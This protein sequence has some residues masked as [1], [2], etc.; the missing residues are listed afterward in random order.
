MTSSP[1][2]PE[3][4]AILRLELEHRSLHLVGFV[5]ADIR[6]IAHH[7][8]EIVDPAHRFQHIALQKFHPAI[9]LQP[10][11][12]GAGNLQRVRG[13]I[14]PKYFRRPQF[15]RQRQC[16]AARTRPHIDNLR[17]RGNSRAN[18][19]TVSTRCSVSGR[20]ISTAGDTTKSSPQNS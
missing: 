7:E 20:G 10:R 14:D 15:I 19:N 1:L 17:V 9:Q 2:S 18:S 6:R 13:K 3:N 8:I 5:F 11:S 16:N 4:T 12:V